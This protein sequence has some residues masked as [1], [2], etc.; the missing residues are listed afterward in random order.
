MQ[1]RWMAAGLEA[2]RKGGVAGV[3]IERLAADL[4]ISKGSF[5]WHFRD[6]EHLLQ[7][8][9]DY[10]SRE[11]TELEF[12]RIRGLP[13]RLGERLLA[14]ARDVLEKGM[15]RYD[16]PIRAWARSHRGV[17]ATVEEVDRRRVRALTQLFEEGG[18]SGAAARTRARLFYTFLL[19]EPQVRAPRRHAEELERMVAVLA[20]R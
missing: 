4:G 16:P 9:L 11:M 8:L 10:W 15:G 20:A 3:R 2:L 6:R 17:A 12:E 7:A 19:G 13:P 1:Q 18:F 5:Y 14:L